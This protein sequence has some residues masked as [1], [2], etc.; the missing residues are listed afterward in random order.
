MKRIL[1]SMTALLLAWQALAIPAK[2]G[3]FP[4][5]QPDGSVVM[6]ELHGDEF[7]SWTTLAGTT[8][9][10]ALDKDGYWRPTTIKESQWAAARGR[11]LQVEE[12]R[13]IRPFTH[14]D[15]KMTHG[16]RHIPV[17]LV[18][19]QDQKFVLDNP[20]ERFNAMLNEVGYS[21]DGATGSV[22]D[23][24]VENSKGLFQPVFDVY[25]PVTLPND[26]AYYGKPVRNEQGEVTD[27]DEHPELALYHAAQALDS[28]VDF[29]QYDYNQDGKVDMTLFYYPGYNEAEHA[30]ENT[31]WPHQWSLQSSPDSQAR[32]A[33]FDGLKLGN[34]F[35]TSEL[36]G[37]SGANMC[38]IGTTC[39]EF[40]HSLGLPDF[41]DTDYEKNGECSAMYY[42][43]IMAKGSYMNQSRTPPYFNA[44]ERICLGWL[45]ESDIPEMPSGTVSFGTIQ[46]DHVYKTSTVT[47]GEYFLYECRDGSGWDAY[48]PQGMLAIHVDKS[49]MRTV[50]GQTPSYYWK[51]FPSVNLINAYGEHP[52]CYVIPASA[53]QDLLYKGELNTWIF[54]GSAEV[55]SYEPVDWEG[56]PVGVSLTGISFADGKVSLTAHYSS[57]KVVKGSVIDQEENG[58]E[59]VYLR[60]TPLSNDMTE[61][62][63]IYDAL[64]DKEGIFYIGLGELDAPYAR[65]TLTKEGYKTLTEDIELGS[66]TVI[67]YFV[68]EEGGHEE[69]TSFGQLGI[70]AIADPK[71]GSYTAGDVFQLNMDMPSGLL[72]TV[73]WKFDGHTVTDPVTLQA[74][75]HVVSATLVYGDGSTETLE[76][77]IDVK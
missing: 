39:H 53:Q 37:N 15:N 27:H 52:C 71:L 23:Y 74:G 5:T 16:T 34:Y 76:L 2:P 4:Y 49:T 46:N 67:T 43:S 41:Y 51:K 13:R 25:G 9:V 3:A 73:S 29:S 8:Q 38:G 14:N 59:G 60:L 30:P 18:E 11:R 55:T 48:I 24:Y 56:N 50:G 47:E 17:L 6:L 40:G 26:M 54:P 35:C 66:R 42:F 10:V 12:S 28:S 19:F 63:G 57:E 62:P 1:V 32:S 44:E 31:I 64:S 36:R 70:P 77:Q 20:Q 68:M 75:I 69:A 7:I 58:L 45:L 22:Q 61:L 33:K 72:P 21:Y 65:V